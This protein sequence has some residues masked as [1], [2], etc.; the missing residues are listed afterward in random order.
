MASTLLTT[1][2]CTRA[3]RVCRSLTACEELKSIMT[4]AG[5]SEQLSKPVTCQQWVKG[6]TWRVGEGETHRVD[7]LRLGSYAG[8]GLMDQMSSHE[9][10]LITLHSMSCRCPVLQGGRKPGA[11]HFEFVGDLE[12]NY[13][14]QLDGHGRR[15]GQ[16]WQ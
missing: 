15:W 10:K 14:L 13:S 1:A 11:K 8:I 6:K 9:G 16:R 2:L 3:R 4:T 5:K 12:V 7:I